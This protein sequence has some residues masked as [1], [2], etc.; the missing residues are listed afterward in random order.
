MREKARDI[1]FRLSRICK[2]A[3]VIVI[4][5]ELDF[6]FFGYY[7]WLRVNLSTSVAL[8]VVINARIQ[9]LSQYYVA[10]VMQLDGSMANV[11][12]SPPLSHSIIKRIPKSNQRRV[13]SWIQNHDYLKLILL[14]RYCQL[15]NL[16]DIFF[17]NYYFGNETITQS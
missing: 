13:V 15:K 5:S 8:F 17:I 4:L 16:K 1:R 2:S 7:F 6:L 10:N 3:T 14:E 9:E 12:V 11:K